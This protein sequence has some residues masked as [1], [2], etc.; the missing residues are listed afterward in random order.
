MSKEDNLKT[1]SSEE[2][3]VQGAKG[4]KASGE[5]R[6]KKRDQKAKMKMILDLPPTAEAREV[7]TDM[8]VSE[9]DI[10]NDTLLCAALFKSAVEGNV[11]AFDRIMFLLGKDIRSQEMKLK[12]DTFNLKKKSLECGNDEALKKLDDVLANIEMQI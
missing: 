8:G 11:Q 4:G 10:D 12:R 6:R 7:L 3:R 5:A 9:E 2:A 1:L